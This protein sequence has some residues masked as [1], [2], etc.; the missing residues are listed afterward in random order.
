[1]P[2]SKYNNRPFLNFNSFDADLFIHMQPQKSKNV[3]ILP[4]HRIKMLQG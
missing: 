4:M 1:M 2:F 3:V